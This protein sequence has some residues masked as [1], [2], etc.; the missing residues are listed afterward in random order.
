VRETVAGVSF[1]FRI[2]SRFAEI[3]SG[4]RMT[5][6][7]CR[8]PRYLAVSQ[9]RMGAFASKRRRRKPSSNASVAASVDDA[10]HLAESL[11]ITTA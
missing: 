10:R 8:G 3:R 6:P 1:G 4:E 7:L 2:P 9:V 11:A 5:Y